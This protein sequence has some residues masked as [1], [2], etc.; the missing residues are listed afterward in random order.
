MEGPRELFI[1][2]SAEETARSEARQGPHSW[3]APSVPD[4][5]F[6]MARRLGKLPPA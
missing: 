5:S 4:F 6:S 2:E 3:I 1:R